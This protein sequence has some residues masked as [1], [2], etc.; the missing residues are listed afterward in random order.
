MITYVGGEIT[1]YKNTENKNVSK[2]VN[3]KYTNEKLNTLT[4]VRKV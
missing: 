2:Y 1:F 3:I 4:F